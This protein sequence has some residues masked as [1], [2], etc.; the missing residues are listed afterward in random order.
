MIYNKSSHPVE[1]KK[2]SVR[3]WSLRSEIEGAIG[4]RIKECEAAGVPLYI[5]D[6]KKFYNMEMGVPLTDNV[7]QMESAPKTDDVNSLMESLGDEVKSDETP[8]E[9]APVEAAP[10]EA[11]PAEATPA[12]PPPAEAAPVEAQATPSADVAATP[13]NKTLAEA[14]A[15]MAEQNKAGVENKINPILDRPY[16]RQAPDLDQISYGFAFLADMNMEYVLTFTKDKFLQGQSIVIE[17]LVPQPFKMSA[18]IA[19]CSHYALRSK[20]I[21]NTKPDYRVQCLFTFAHSGER[22]N[23]RRF[24]KSVEP[25]VTQEKKKKKVT[26]DEALGL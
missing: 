14:D 11:A 9:A 6:I 21:S 26:E 12:E 1:V 4:R 18:D 3:I 22:D 2:I 15:I 16:T 5:D 8:T 13:E 23:L 10:T 20:I 17:F 7:L 19:Y 25:T 24:L